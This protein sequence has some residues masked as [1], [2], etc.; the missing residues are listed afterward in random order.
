MEARKLIAMKIEKI[1]NSKNRLGLI[2]ALTLISFAVISRILPH[3]ANFTPI[4]AVALFGGAILPRR[5]AVSLPLVAMIISDLVIGLHPL[6][7]FTWGSFAAIALISSYRF[8][9]ISTSNVLYGSLGASILFYVVSNFGVWAE[10][11]LY[12]LTL[13]GLAQC[14]INA[15]PFFRNTLAGDMVYAGLLFGAYAL[16]T[17]IANRQ[18]TARNT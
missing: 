13:E 9:K 1:T 10:G 5:W 18:I 17:S 2:I 6:V 15:L 12:A 11:R 16:A 8:K 7:M 3:P 14:Y 4:A